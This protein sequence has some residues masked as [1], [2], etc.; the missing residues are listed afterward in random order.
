MF[1]P[2]YFLQISCDLKYQRSDKRISTESHEYLKVLNSEKNTF[3]IKKRKKITTDQATWTE[4]D[5]V[6]TFGAVH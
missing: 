3:E 4:T 1:P 5:A 2:L 6:D